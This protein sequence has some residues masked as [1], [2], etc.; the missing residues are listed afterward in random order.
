MENPGAHEGGSKLSGQDPAPGRGRH[1]SR[2]RSA[3]GE[4][5]E[6][7]KAQTA[8]APRKEKGTATKADPRFHDKLTVS[9]PCGLLFFPSVSPREASHIAHGQR[10]IA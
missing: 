9:Y 6:C 3:G 1:V 2:R 5:V 7:T 8:V 10:R 4:G